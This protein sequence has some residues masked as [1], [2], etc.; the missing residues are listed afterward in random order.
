MDK[1]F[2][3]APAII[4]QAA[5]S[6]L[7]IFA[8]M[9]IVL[10]VLGFFYFR[11]ASEKARLTSFLML[12]VGCAAFGFAVTRET[13]PAPAPAPASASSPA[14]SASCSVSGVVINTVDQQ[15]L[16]GVI[17]GFDE[18]EGEKSAKRVKFNAAQT[19]L[20]GRF[21]V[22][23]DDIDDSRFPL[24]IVLSHRNWIATHVTAVKVEKGKERNDVNL[25]VRITANDFRFPPHKKVPAIAPGPV[26]KVVTIETLGRA[27]SYDFKTESVGNGPTEGDF[28]F[29][30]THPSFW[31][32]NQG[33]GGIVDV[34]N[35]EKPLDQLTAPETRYYKYGVPA[36]VG[37][38]YVAQAKEGR[39]GDYIIFR[40]LDLSVQ[41]EGDGEAT[42]RYVLQYLY[43]QGK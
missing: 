35:N 39:E 17:I 19:G 2:E 18:Y 36:L 5:A 14:P 11:E 24:R 15:P 12:F 31:G 25:P 33:Q 29:S 30:G 7:G 41:G 26:G 34:G 3:S 4:Q 23:C 38:V 16:V 37:R 21:K 43:R 10:G 32:N 22:Y 1:L 6:R 9:I 42:Q 40:V 20:G 13:P 27:R 8:L 28:Y